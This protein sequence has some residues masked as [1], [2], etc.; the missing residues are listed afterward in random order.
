MT[1]KI[2]QEAYILIQEIEELGGMAKA[3]ETG[4]PK[5]KIEEAAAIKQSKIDSGKDLIV[6][7]NIFE[8]D[9]NIDFELLEIERDLSSN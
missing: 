5:L 2:A 8:D 6:G 1:E 7:L 9:E 4:I 3:I